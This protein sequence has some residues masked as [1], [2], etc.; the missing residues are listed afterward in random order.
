MRQ[1]GVQYVFGEIQE[2]Q[3]TDEVS[4]SLKEAQHENAQ[5]WCILFTNTL[6]S[7]MEMLH[8]KFLRL[9]KNFFVLFH[10]KGPA[11]PFFY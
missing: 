9:L 4:S 8:V 2:E 11:E 6:L 10:G 7:Q 1:V 3:Q 5:W